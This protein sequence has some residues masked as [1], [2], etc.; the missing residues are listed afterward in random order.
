M[1]T[2]DAV[3][4]VGLR[5]PLAII[6]TPTVPPQEG[7]VRVKVLWTASTPLD[8]HQ[9]DGGLFVNYPHILGDGLGGE[10][11]EVGSGVDSLKVGDQVGN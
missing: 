4:T 10:V 8:L 3:A 1:A 11:V 5:Q 2:H 9:S 6:Q 7:E